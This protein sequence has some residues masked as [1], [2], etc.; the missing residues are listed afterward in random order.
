MAPLKIA[1]TGDSFIVDAL[2]AQDPTLDALHD[3]LAQHDVRFTNLEVVLHNF[4]QFPSPSSG[5]T[6]AAARP[7][8]LD[9]L[10]RLGFN[11]F[12][13]A[14]NHNLDWLHGGILSTQAALDAR[15]LSYTGI[16]RT[17]ADASKVAYLSTATTRVAMISVT[18]SFQ[19][20]HRAGDG[21]FDVLGRPGIHPLGHKKTHLVTA[22]QM[23][24][25][26]AINQQTTINA[27][28]NLDIKEGFITAEGDDFALGSEL[29]FQIGEPGTREA[30]DEK[31]WLRIKS[32]I[33]EAKRQADL[34]IVSFHSHEFHYPNKDEPA[35]FIRD[36]CYRCIDEGADLLVGH[37]PHILRGIEVYKR[38][39]IFYSLGNF[40][41]QNDLVERQPRDFY[42]LYKLGEQV[43]IAEAL[44]VRSDFGKRGLAI[45]ERVWNSVI[46]SVELNE[47]GWAIC[48]QPI[49]LGFT[50]P[51]SRKGRPRLCTGEKAQMILQQLQAK[52]APFGTQLTIR[53]DQGLLTI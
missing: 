52:S 15:H 42:D 7:E 40:I 3:Y 6:W 2:P 4:E 33:H 35:D 5:G 24:V 12:A 51:R 38:K 19:K 46:A 8:R 31:D 27:A 37:G 30:L 9:D 10:T 16:G 32:R 44:D 49:E 53:G 39:P 43:S 34:V 47:E 21:R 36:F 1:L 26:Q 50:T 22:E 18:S 45:D 28:R 14:N 17:L 20:W 29:L 48:L 41:F 11:L 23:K 25:L 13:C